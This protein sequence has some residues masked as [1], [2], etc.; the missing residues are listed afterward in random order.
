M[1]V[2]GIVVCAN[3]ATNKERGRKHARTEDGDSLELASETV[4]IAAL[5][6]RPYSSDTSM[7]VMGLDDSSSMQHA[8][9]SMSGTETVTGTKEAAE[10]RR[11][12]RTSASNKLASKSSARSQGH[13][14]SM[15]VA[16]DGSL[17]LNGRRAFGTR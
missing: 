2:L 8:R 3:A 15:Q 1:P 17:L 12:K 10:P 9:S 16:P 11:K 4:G 5:G 13:G 6:G 7:L 14:S